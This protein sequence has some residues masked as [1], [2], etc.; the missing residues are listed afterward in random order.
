MPWSL[1]LRLPVQGKKPYDVFSL[2]WIPAMGTETK[3]KFFH[4][5]LVSSS[6]GEDDQLQSVVA[7]MSG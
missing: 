2:S 5:A 7:E 6:A 4:F 1:V 3:L